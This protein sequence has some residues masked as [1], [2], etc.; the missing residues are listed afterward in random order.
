[1]EENGA[2]ALPARPSHVESVAPS[3]CLI[4]MRRDDATLN[5]NLPVGSHN[6]L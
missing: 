3:K 2:H 5:L 6:K 4:R 1:M